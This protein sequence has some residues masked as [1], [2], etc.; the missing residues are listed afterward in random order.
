MFFFGRSGSL[1]LCLGC[2]SFFW[3][4]KKILFFLW[5]FQILF[6]R[7]YSKKNLCGSSKLSLKPTNFQHQK[8]SGIIFKQFFH[9]IKFLLSNMIFYTSLHLPL[10]IINYHGW[11]L[12]NTYGAE[13]TE[14]THMVQHGAAMWR[15][16]NLQISI[17]PTEMGKVSQGR[18]SIYHWLVVEPTP[19]D[20]MA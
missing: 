19:M 8:S 7:W 2:S 20:N 16:K 18:C 10:I 3:Q 9:H 6:F 5:L 17:D 1:F 12:F 15:A 14:G 11:F 4:F 13:E